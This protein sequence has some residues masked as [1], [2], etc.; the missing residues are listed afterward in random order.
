MNHLLANDISR[1]ICLLCLNLQV[2][3]K[4]DISWESF[5]FLTAVTKLKLSSSSNFV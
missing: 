5:A 1:L 2:K 4:V 3:N